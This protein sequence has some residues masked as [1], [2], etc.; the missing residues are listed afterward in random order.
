MSFN[1]MAAITIHSDFQF[2][3]EPKATL[4]RIVFI[5]SEKEKEEDEKKEGASQWEGFPVNY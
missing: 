3:C 2:Y 5:K 4:R 1:F